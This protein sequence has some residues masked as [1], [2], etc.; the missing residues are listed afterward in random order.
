MQDGR[1]R[2][3]EIHDYGIFETDLEMV[4]GTYVAI[5]GALDPKVAYPIVIMLTNLT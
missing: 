3:N 5:G 1:E 2:K 4:L